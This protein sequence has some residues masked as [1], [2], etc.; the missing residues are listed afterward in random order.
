M[1]KS[2][3]HR[4]WCKCSS[5]STTQCTKALES[6]LSLESPVR[7]LSPGF[8]SQYQHYLNPQCSLY[9][10]GSTSRALSIQ[11]YGQEH[12]SLT[13]KSQSHTLRAETLSTKAARRKIKGLQITKQ[14]KRPRSLQLGSKISKLSNLLHGLSHQT[15][16]SANKQ[17]HSSY[18]S[19]QITRIHK[20]GFITYLSRVYSHT[21][22]ELILLTQAASAP[23]PSRITQH[24]LGKGFIK[25]NHSKKGTAGG[26]LVT[27]TLAPAASAN[28]LFIR[29]ATGSQVVLYKRCSLS[30]GVVHTTCPVSQGV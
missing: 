17:P 22:E 9:M 24:H 21:G 27:P 6:N 19:H 13:E 1:R 20:K 4:W 10:Q 8:L 25:H 28:A 26:D 16:P 14:I 15:M 5:S 3:N 18:S 12:L 2:L 29:K 30:F 7:I 11:T 23:P